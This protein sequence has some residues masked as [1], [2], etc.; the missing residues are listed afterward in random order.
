MSKSHVFLSKIKS[1][2]Y[3]LLATAAVLISGCESE[4]AFVK[5]PSEAQEALDLAPRFFGVND[6]GT[7]WGD[8]QSALGSFGHT[9]VIPVVLYDDLMNPS[10]LSGVVE[11]SWTTVVDVRN[12]IRTFNYL[13]RSTKTSKEAS[14]KNCADLNVVLL[15]NQSSNS[16][17]SAIF[18]GVSRAAF[19]AL[20]QHYPHHSLLP[21][22][23]SKTTSTNE[24]VYSC[25]YIFS[26]T[27]PNYISS[28]GDLPSTQRFKKI[29]NDV[30]STTTV[31]AYGEK[32]IDD[33]IQTTFSANGDSIE[34][35]VHPR[36][37]K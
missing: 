36:K 14:D 5:D 4:D 18:C 3:L 8:I 33:F 26:V 21:V 22:L 30:S 6:S 9:D 13:N 19:S 23:V 11:A 24:E 31:N 35:M 25:G 20:C 15:G 17:V 1:L 27:D 37:S 34:S 7:V 28:P 16:R 10:T 2:S 12:A 32:F 29:W